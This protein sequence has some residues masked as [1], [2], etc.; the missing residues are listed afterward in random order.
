MEILMDLLKHV[1]DDEHYLNIF[2]GH[3]D[4]KKCDKS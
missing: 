1:V 3:M 2:D 4:C